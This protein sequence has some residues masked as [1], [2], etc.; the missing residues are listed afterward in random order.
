MLSQI[1]QSLG[2]F[3]RAEKQVAE[4]VLAHPRQATESTVAQV[5]RACATSEPS[6]IRFCRR[7]GLSGFRELTIRLTESLSRPGSLV[8][9]DVSAG[10]SVSDATV[11][12][13]EAAINSLVDLRAQLSTMPFDAVVTRMVDARQFVFAG[14]GASGHVASDASHKFFRLGIP[15][16]ALTDTPSIRQF[17]AIAGPHD[18]L[19]LISKNGSAQPVCDAAAQA[20]SNGAFV[21]AITDPDSPLAESASTTFACDAQEDTNIYTPRSSRL[22]HLALLDALHVSTALALGDTAADN[23]E[24]SKD[25]LIA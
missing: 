6:V 18:V 20:H 3:S 12:V 14:L 11:K 2:R 10:D 8:H 22:V 21:V 19:F 16:N 23:L 24:R 1:N 4:W 7:L 9:R 13:V 25:A 17:A 5:A 15:C